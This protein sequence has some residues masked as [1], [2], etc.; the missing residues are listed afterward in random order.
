[1]N[2]RDN[3]IDAGLSRRMFSWVRSRRF[4]VKMLSPRLFP[5]DWNLPF[6]H[7]VS[8]AYISSSCSGRAFSVPA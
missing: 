3:P 2:K 8:P 6:A 7:L 5:R 1:M 4:W